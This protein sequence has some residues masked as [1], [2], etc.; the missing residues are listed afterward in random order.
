MDPLTLSM[1][2]SGI[3]AGE[4]LI[5]GGA[6]LLQGNE[7]TMFQ[8]QNLANAL[9]SNERAH[10]ER[11]GAAGGLRFDQ[12]GNSTY[13]DPTQ[14]RWV[15]DYTPTQ[16]RLIDEGEARQGRTNVRGAQ[17]SQDYDRLRGEYLYDHPKT[18][19][20]SY[21]ELVNLI[22]GA[23]GQGDRALSTLV[24]RQALRQQGNLPV[25]NA[26]QYG[27]KTPGQQ[28]AAQMLQ[29]RGAA[30]DESL[31]REAGHTSKYL[32]ALQAFE[33][34][35]NTVAPLDP[36]GSVI[37]QMEG[38]GRSDVLSADAD[39][40]KLI[41]SIFAQGGQNIGHAYD[42]AV[43]GAAAFGAGGGG[44]AGNLGQL[45]KLAAGTGGTLGN[46]KGATYSGGGG[47]GG[48]S[49]IGS[50]D[51]RFNFGPT[52]KGVGGEAAPFGGAPYYSGIVPDPYGDTAKVSSFNDRFGDD[53]WGF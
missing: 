43:K 15:T 23:Q 37:K 14:R 9:A 50:W 40:E 51:R 19:A 32:P 31:K 45:A 26:S 38:Q 21:A 2:I 44:G 17:A 18:E 10:G 47:G 39:Y 6:A 27:E 52:T 24:G 22:Q 41:A 7:S 16:Q 36:T 42:T 12:F 20:E 35:A 4:K 29:A 48:G 11:L 28:L 25:I 1:L 5:G 46:T 49:D 53:Y 33:R 30:L 8:E 13:Y 34:T 3:G